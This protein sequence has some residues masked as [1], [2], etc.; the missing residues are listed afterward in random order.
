MSMSLLRLV[1]RTVSVPLK[2]TN[3]S[4][5][6]SSIADL[7][8]EYSKQGLDDNNEVVSK[9]PYEL[10]KNWFNEATESKV[11]EPNAMSLATCHNNI[12]SA[13]I[14][15][16]KGFD[17]NGFVWYTNY[18]SRKSSELLQNPNAA[19]TFWWGDLERSIRIEGTVTKVSDEESDKYFHSRPRNSQIGAWT[20]NQSSKIVNRKD[21]ESQEEEILKK[22][23]NQEVIPR[24]PHWG[25]FRLTPIRMEFW[26]G[27]ESRLHD[28]ILFELPDGKEKDCNVMKTW[29][30]SRL[31]P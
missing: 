15:L 8:K 20:S 11:L 22:F 18:N 28:R 7:R 5:S 27:R 29:K 19:I 23:N 13:R 24:P 14:V 2:S 6:L 25:G 26:K 17:E 4:N 12:P 1:R 10:F 3:N 31:Q 9:G 16:L 21:L 30:I